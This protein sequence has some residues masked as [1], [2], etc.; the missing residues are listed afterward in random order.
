MTDKYTEKTADIELAA[1]SNDAQ[2][3]RI[4]ELFIF[5]YEGFAIMQK[6]INAGTAT[7]ISSM[8]A[9]L[10]AMQTDVN[11]KLHNLMTQLSTTDGKLSSLDAA[12]RQIDMTVQGMQQGNYGG[13]QQGQKQTDST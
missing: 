1:D 11:Q 6:Q 10:Q 8:G 4:I 5:T 3:S 9:K 13:A 12:A 7:A 2:L